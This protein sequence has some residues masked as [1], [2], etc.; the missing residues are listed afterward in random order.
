MI[1]KLSIFPLLFLLI[2]CGKENNNKTTADKTDSIAVSEEVKPDAAD[3]QSGV[4]ER[5]LKEIIFKTDSVKKHLN[6]KN[7]LALYL[8]FREDTGELI[9]KIDKD[10]TYIL[11]NF[12]THV[13]EK[14]QKLN[15]PDS[16]KTKFRDIKKANIEFWEIGE[17]YIEIRPK[18]DYYQK[19]FDNKLSADYNEFVKL[20]A[21]ENKDLI[22]A[23][24]GLTIS[25]EELSVLVLNWENFL[26][27]YPNSKLYAEVKENYK[28]L[29][30]IYLF[31]LDNTPTYE[32]N[33]DNV[34]E[35]YN[36][37]K[38]EFERFTSKNPESVASK[39]VLSLLEEF[40]NKSTYDDLHKKRDQEF[41]KYPI[42]K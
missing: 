9:G 30:N 40:K 5:A 32:N 24:A 29:L 19:I 26:L 4:T 25:F 38:K 8:K 3:N 11:D 20:E 41:L 28:N 16:L 35:L 15:L 6:R 18:A 2:S 34:L 13:S 10:N 27:K 17:G 36:E 31:G 14:T 21:F 12:Y 23:D 39:I 7:A 33:G 1:Q 42:T 22:G 37:N